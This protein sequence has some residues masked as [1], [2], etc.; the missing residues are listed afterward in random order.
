M[1]DAPATTPVLSYVSPPTRKRRWAW[2]GFWA[3]LFLGAA[4]AS[5]TQ[6]RP[7][8]NRWRDLRTAQETFLAQQ[9]AW[10]RYTAPADQLVFSDDPNDR[11]LSGFGGYH[12][13]RRQVVETH[14]QLANP[15]PVPQPAQPPPPPTGVVYADPGMFTEMHFVSGATLPPSNGIKIVQ[16]ARY[17]SVGIGHHPPGINR[18][19]ADGAATL[20]LHGRSSPGGAGRIVAINVALDENS[21]D[22]LL[23]VRVAEPATRR[24]GSQ[25]RLLSA[26]EYHIRHGEIGRLRIF[27]GQPDPADPARFTIGYEMNGHAG[28]II[29]RLNAGDAVKLDF[30]N[31]PIE[32]RVASDAQ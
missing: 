30:S 27:A 16:S 12:L 2:R 7:H 18:R 20:F 3:A 29:G 15:P 9:A 4:I 10:M 11:Q 14:L 19:F 13:I 8:L 25:P 23:S 1:N 21:S 17:S 24:I 22:L 26:Q 32:S 31:G 5:W 6:L 28:T